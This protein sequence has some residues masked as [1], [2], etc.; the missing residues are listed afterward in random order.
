M[1][2]WCAT[3]IVVENRDIETIRNLKKEFEK[4]FE[5][6]EIKN[7]F[8]KMWLGNI[9]S[10]LGYN[11]NEVLHGN[12]SC[13]GEVSYM[14]LCN[15][16]LMICTETAWIPMLKVIVMMVEKYAPD[17]SITYSAIEEGCGIYSTNDPDVAETVYVDIFEDL[18]E[19]LSWVEEVNDGNISKDEFIKDIG[20][21]MGWNETDEDLESKVFS[22]L[23]DLFSYNVWEY[24]EINEW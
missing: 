2:N 19:E 16:T 11:E 1:A 9:L 6:N 13:R 10:Y 5:C 23:A 12:I 22:E 17:S 20:A 3:T 21:S 14:E 15:N 4:A 8:G 7:G 24:R 18:P